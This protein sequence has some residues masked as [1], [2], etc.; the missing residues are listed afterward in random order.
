MLT[1]DKRLMS[2]TLEIL[3]W[4]GAHHDECVA[5]WAGPMA[6]PGVAQDVL[7]PVHIAGPAFYEVEPQWLNETWVDLARSGRTLRAQV[8]THAGAAFH[9]P[10]DDGFPIVQQAGFLSLVL[11]DHASRDDLTGAYLCHLNE[12]G[13]WREVPLRQGLV[14]T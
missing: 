10:S 8:H 13:E 5:Y 4:C 7:H 6:R 12:S 11:P 2:E 14:I 1:L 3:R 9:S